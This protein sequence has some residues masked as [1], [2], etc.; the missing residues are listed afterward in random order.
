MTFWGQTSAILR[1]VVGANLAE[2][3]TIH[4]LLQQGK[5]AA[6]PGLTLPRVG[7][8]SPSQVLGPL[9]EFARMKMI[10]DGMPLQDAVEFADYLGAVAIGYDRFSAGPQTVGGA[11][12]VL[13]I[14]PEGL[15]WYRR[16]PFAEKMARA[17]SEFYE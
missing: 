14:Q 8:L 11:L 6:P 7:P 15:S 12:D 17:R 3:D 10:L 13:A 1:L 2:F 16:K 9:M 5:F 4:M